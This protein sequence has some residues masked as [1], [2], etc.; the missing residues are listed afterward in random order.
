MRRCFSPLVG[1]S[2][3]TPAA[4]DWAAL[5]NR[6]SWA[7]CAPRRAT[8]AL[9]RCSLNVMSPSKARTSPRPSSWSAAAAPPPLL[10]G[11]HAP[12]PRP[13][14]AS[15]RQQTKTGSVRCAHSQTTSQ[16]HW[17]EYTPSRRGPRGESSS[18]RLR[19]PTAP[20]I[21]HPPC[22]LSRLC[23]SSAFVSV[24]EPL[25]VCV[26]WSLAGG[27]RGWRALPSARWGNWWAHSKAS[28]PCVQA[29]NFRCSRPQPWSHPQAGGSSRVSHRVE[30]PPSRLQ[31][32]PGVRQVG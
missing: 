31:A 24:E 13:R 2:S 11:L 6:L 30:L 16:S 8:L 14:Q 19:L 5:T 27:H 10:R 21:S 18:S 9:C 29:L 22:R 15:L 25:I 20:A 1:P 17:R 12:A 4:R 26:R 28:A 23:A 3:S 32:T 7:G